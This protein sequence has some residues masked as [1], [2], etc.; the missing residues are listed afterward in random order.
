[1]YVLHWH[2][3]CSG[4]G[5]LNSHEVRCLMVGSSQGHYGGRAVQSEQKDGESG[6]SA[7]SKL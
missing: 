7:Y 1:M 5:F 3:H 6:C 2:M 4:T